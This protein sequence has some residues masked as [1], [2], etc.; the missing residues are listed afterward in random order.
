MASYE[1]R[2]PRSI[3]YDNIDSDEKRRTSEIG[4]PARKVQAE[5]LELLERLQMTLSK[6]QICDEESPAGQ[7]SGTNQGAADMERTFGF[8]LQPT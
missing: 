6:R 8:V 1:E 2:N 7:D 3:Y 4:S 5:G